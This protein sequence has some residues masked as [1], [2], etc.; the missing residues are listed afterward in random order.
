MRGVSRA[1]KFF[2]LIWSDEPLGWM[3]H[4]TCLVT[5]VHSRSI[6]RFFKKERKLLRLRRQRRNRPLRLL[7][8]SRSIPGKTMSM[9][10]IEVKPIRGGW[11]VLEAP[12]I[13]PVF[14]GERGW[15]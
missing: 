11:K 6:I 8:P 5:I 12:G 14:P 2:S 7:F 15:E 1:T 4:E 13:E 3:E 9:K 10:A